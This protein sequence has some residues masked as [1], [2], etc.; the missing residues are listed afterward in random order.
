MNVALLQVSKFSKYKMDNIASLTFELMTSFFSIYS[1]STPLSSA[2]PTM[3][4]CG[5]A[6]LRYDTC[7]GFVWNTTNVSM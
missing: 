6:C 2:A 1:F 5:S 3:I 7:A 4:A